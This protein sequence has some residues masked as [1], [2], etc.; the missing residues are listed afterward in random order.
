MQGNSFVGRGF[1]LHFWASTTGLYKMEIDTC[2]HRALDFW[3]S[4]EALVHLKKE[5]RINVNV[6]KIVRK[7][8]N[9]NVD[10]IVRINK[11]KYC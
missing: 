3:D 2:S 11:C 5:S 4:C 9:V 10:K 7:S 8:L 1:M 6:V